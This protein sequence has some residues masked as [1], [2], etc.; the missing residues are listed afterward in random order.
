[1]SEIYQRSSTIHITQK[2]LHCDR[3]FVG[4]YHNIQVS[5]YADDVNNFDIHSSM[6][7]CL[8]HALRGGF[9]DLDSVDG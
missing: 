5:I 3:L 9:D 6:G 8:S 4:T 1:M 7:I 2:H